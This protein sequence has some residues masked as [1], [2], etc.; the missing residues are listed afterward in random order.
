MLFLFFLFLRVFILFTA[1]PVNMLVKNPTESARQ[2]LTYDIIYEF[3][4]RAAQDISMKKLNEIIKRLED[5]CGC[6]VE[7]VE[8]SSI[9]FILRFYSQ[10]SLDKFRGQCL[11]GA[12]AKKLTDHLM[13]D[14]DIREVS[15]KELKIQMIIKDTDYKEARS[16]LEQSREYI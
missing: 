8:K 14:D 9:R 5:E 6:V 1:V 7:R 13:T 3:M 16:I 2:K 11:N 12:L 4:K 10:E 15:G